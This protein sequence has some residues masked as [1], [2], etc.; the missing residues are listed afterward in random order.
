MT[1]TMVVELGLQ[2]MTIA[3]KLSAPILLTALAIGFAISLFQSVTQIQ[4]ATLSFVPKAVAIGAVLLFTGNWMLHQMM[5]YT[6]QLFDKVPE[7]LR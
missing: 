4:E 3:A 6:T 2:A 5:T 1:D 7:L